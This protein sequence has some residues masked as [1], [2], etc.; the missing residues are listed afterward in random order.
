MKRDAPFRAKRSILIAFTVWAVIVLA[1]P[2]TLAPGSVPDLSGRAG[3]VDNM[4]AIGGMNPLGAAVYLAGDVY[5]HQRLERSFTENGNEMPFCARD[6]GIFLG[7]AVGMLL[8]IVLRPRFHLIVLLALLFPILLDGGLQY[9]GLHEST[10]ALRLLTGALG[11]AGCSYLLAHMAD[12]KLSS[13][14]IA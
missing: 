12:R 3:E 5:C 8:M 10:N 6:V 11:G 2:W 14:V 13:A 1:V 4:D 9:I 7:L